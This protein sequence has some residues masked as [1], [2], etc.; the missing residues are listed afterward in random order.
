MEV[1]EIKVRKKVKDYVRYNSQLS[2]NV[3]PA[4]KLKKN[5]HQLT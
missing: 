2:K 1:Y 4:K 5:I 3:S